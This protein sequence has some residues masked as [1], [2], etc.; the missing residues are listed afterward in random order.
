MRASSVFTTS[1]PAYGAARRRSASTSPGGTRGGSCRG[2][3]AGARG[4]DGQRGERPGVGGQARRR[5]RRRGGRRAR[6]RSLRRRGRAAIR[7]RARREAADDDLGNQVDD[8]RGV[9]RDGVDGRGRLGLG[10]RLGLG[11]GRRGRL[12]ARKQRVAAPQQLLRA[13][14]ERG[15]VGDGRGAA[16]WRRPRRPAVRSRASARRSASGCDG[17]ASGRF[18]CRRMVAVH[19]RR[20][21]RWQSYFV[22]SATPGSS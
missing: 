17:D 19:A 20:R 2:G 11:R 15:D 10:L 1:S 18:R 7:R 14:V 22:W 6:E 12:R 8:G 5:P 13:R 16:G 21:P 4:G 9:G 3:A